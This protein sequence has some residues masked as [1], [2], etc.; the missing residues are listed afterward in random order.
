MMLLRGMVEEDE[1]DPKDIVNPIRRDVDEETKARDLHALSEKNFVPLKTTVDRLDGKVQTQSTPN[2]KQED[3][4]LQKARRPSIQKDKPWFRVEH[5]R[6]AL[7]FRSVI[8]DIKTFEQVLEFLV[9]EVGLSVVKIDLEKMCAGTTWGWRC[10]AVDF[11]FPSANGQLIEYYATFDA[12]MRAND[13]PCHALYEQG[14][15]LAIDDPDA[16]ELVEKSADLYD[17][18]WEETL[19]KLNLSQKRFERDWSKLRERLGRP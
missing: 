15:N 1:K 12:V 19:K 5:L 17:E 4:I 16:Q 14:R 9:S 10:V 3:R 2:R 7:R 8:R 11:R 18:A 13:G 6:D